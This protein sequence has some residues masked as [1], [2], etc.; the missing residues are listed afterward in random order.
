MAYRRRRG[1]GY[2]AAD[3]ASLAASV[4]PGS[5]AYQLWSGCA[6]NP[7][8]PACAAN[9]DVEL[10]TGYTTA[11]DQ[12]AFNA[13]V[14]AGGTPAPVPV[15]HSVPAPVAPTAPVLQPSLP[16]PGPIMIGPIP[17]LRTGSAPAAGTL[18]NPAVPPALTPGNRAPAGTSVSTPATTDTETGLSST[19]L[20]LPI[21]AWAIGGLGLVFAFSGGG[22]RG[23]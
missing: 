16:S 17:I 12:S 21:W 11:A 23:R 7:T 1:L 13:A 3:Y 8:A 9:T 19:L 6:Q 15:Q 5:S 14:A 10:Q 20:G 18:A 2:T 4:P 22:W